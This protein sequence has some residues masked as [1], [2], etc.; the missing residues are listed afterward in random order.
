MRIPSDL[1]SVKKF[2]TT[3]EHVELLEWSKRMEKLLKTNKITGQRFFRSLK[4]LEYNNIVNNISIR[5]LEEYK[6]EGVPKKDGNLGGLLS[7]HRNGG[8][9]HPHTDPENGGRHLRF[10]LFLSLP[11]EGGIPIYNGEQINVEER[12]LVPYEADIHEHS[13]T[14][15]VGEKPRIIISFGWVFDA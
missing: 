1:V 2:I 14:K 13:S 5:I 12:M 9:V 7:V 3:D 6:L 4:D 15:V 10:N 11:K 8:H